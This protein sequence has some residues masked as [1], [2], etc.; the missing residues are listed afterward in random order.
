MAPLARPP[1]P[2]RVRV[3]PAFRPAA[4][5]VPGRTPL[6]Q[7]RPREL[8]LAIHLPSLLLDSLRDV[9]LALPGRP[10]VAIVDLEHN[11]KVVRA[12]AEAVQAAGVREGMSINAALALVPDLHALARNAR[13]ERQ[14]LEAVRAGAAVVRVTVA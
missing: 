8:W 13:R 14:L 11:G 9:V 12:C 3:T 5:S 1:S 6:A 2:H 7:S 10:P 4:L